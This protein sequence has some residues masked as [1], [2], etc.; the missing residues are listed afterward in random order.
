MLIPENSLLT[1]GLNNQNRDN[2]TTKPETGVLKDCTRMT[3]TITGRSSWDKL[4][5]VCSSCSRV[6]MRASKRTQSIYRPANART[7]SWGMP[8]MSGT[9]C[10]ESR[11]SRMEYKPIIL[12]EC[13]SRRPTIRI[14]RPILSYYTI[15]PSPRKIM[16]SLTSNSKYLRKKAANRVITLRIIQKNL[17]LASR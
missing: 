14:T 1:P 5:R 7:W 17:V 12:L 16:V 11:L 9:G 4:R 13:C 6:P 15:K 3:R 8:R 10:R 2:L